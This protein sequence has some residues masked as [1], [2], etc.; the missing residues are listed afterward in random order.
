M[1]Q[2]LT[3]NHQPSTTKKTSTVR[4][5]KALHATN[6]RFEIDVNFQ[7]QPYSL[8]ALYGKSGVGKTS[9][10]RML[11]GLMNADEGQI[12]VDNQV[13]LDSKKRVNLKPQKRAVG[14]LFQDYALFPNMTIRQN[15]EFALQDESSS[16]SMFT[17][18]SKFSKHKSTPAPSNEEKIVD[19]LVEIMELTGLQNRYPATLSGGQQQRVALARA[20]VQQPT[21]LLLDEPLSALD[22]EMR[23]KLQHYILQVHRRYQLTTIIVSHDKNEIER[24][25]D[26][27]LI[28]ADGKIIADG[29]PQQVFYKNYPS[30]QN[31][32][33]VSTE[34][35]TPYTWGKI[36]Q[37]WQLANTPQLSV[38]QEL[39]PP[40]VAE[41]RH[42]HRYA[43][44]FFYILKGEA[45]FYIGNKKRIV[46][47]NQGIHILPQTV[48][49]IKNESE[50]ELSFL[51]ISQPH[52]HG[53]RI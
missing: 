30:P 6:G 9:I 25:A 24:L 7:I 20:L 31:G 52:A 51:V 2:P 12:K 48:H 44:Q 49:Q 19:E 53:D 1:P 37:G 11:A 10:L 40:Q 18:L 21:L 39:M 28:L 23:Q 35:I 17:K 46:R 36:C 38:I 50:E 27:V 3:V 22:N 14:M 4:L 29:T 42:A 13:W 41:T 8:V 5:K 32:E 45:T 33:V 15:L 43:Q 26:R 47:A 34:N 16:M